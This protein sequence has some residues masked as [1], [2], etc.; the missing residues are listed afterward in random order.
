MHYCIPT[1]LYLHLTNYKSHD[2]TYTLS[3][4][5]CVQ[6][7]LQFELHTITDPFPQPSGP[8]T[9][10]GCLFS[11]WSHALKLSMKRWTSAVCMTG[12]W[13]GLWKSSTDNSLL[14]CNRSHFNALHINPIHHHHYHRLRSASTTTLVVPP[15]RRATIGDR[16]FPAAASRT[17]NSLPTSVREIQSLPAIRRKLKTAC[18]PSLFRQT[19]C[20]IIKLY[21]VPLKHF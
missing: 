11:G 3:S 2:N 19:D 16:A 6:K 4:T 12:S 10:N 20:D 15:T 9:M 14:I 13:L 21:K 18:L 8:T 7:Y 17:W 1:S 5:H